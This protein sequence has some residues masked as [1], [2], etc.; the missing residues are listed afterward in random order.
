ME[1]SKKVRGNIWTKVSIT[2]RSHPWEDPGSE[3]SR[4]REHPVQKSWSRK[5]H[6]HVQ[7]IERKQVWLQQNKSEWRVLENSWRGRQKPVF[8][9]LVRSLLCRIRLK[10]EVIWSDLP[11]D[12]ILLASVQRMEYEGLACPV[13]VNLVQVFLIFK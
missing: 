12:Q 7:G 6:W 5:Q 8:R 2:K 10:W 4:Q 1:W 3:P 13:F 9:V 11:F